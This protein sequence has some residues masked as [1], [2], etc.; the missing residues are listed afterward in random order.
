MKRLL[1]ITGIAVVSFAQ[2]FAASPS[3]S[4]AQ[5]QPNKSQTSQTSEDEDEALQLLVANDSSM[6]SDA[7]KPAN[8]QQTPSDATQPKMLLAGTTPSAADQTQQQK[9]A[10]DQKN[11][12]KADAQKPVQPQLIA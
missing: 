7:Q 12:Q 9:G 6:S 10:A 3:N 5:T 2:V 1:L 8:Q 4:N 11:G